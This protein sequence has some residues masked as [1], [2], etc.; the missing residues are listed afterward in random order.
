[1]KALKSGMIAFVPTPKFLTR[2]DYKDRLTSKSE[3]D[4]DVDVDDVERD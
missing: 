1:M 4:V 2:Y 3:H